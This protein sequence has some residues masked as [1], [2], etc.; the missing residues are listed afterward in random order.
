MGP[1]RVELVPARDADH[2][3]GFRALAGRADLERALRGGGRSRRARR[4]GRHHVAERWILGTGR[5]L[6]AVRLAPH[7]PRVGP[8]REPGPLDP[9]SCYAYRM[10]MP[11]LTRD[12]E[13][14]PPETRTYEH[15]NDGLCRRHS[16]RSRG[17]PAQ[18][19]GRADVSD[20]R[21]AARDGPRCSVPRVQHV[22]NNYSQ[23]R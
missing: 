7:W 13:D 23:W 2:V 4:A 5:R 16:A 10:V 12:F 22:A 11:T 3:G 1:P 19:H 14:E 8:G 18:G 15:S 9:K 20:R 6:F 17:R 21:D